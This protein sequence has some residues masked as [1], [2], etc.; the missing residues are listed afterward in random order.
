VVKFW[1]GRTLDSRVVTDSVTLSD[2]KLSKIARLVRQDELNS[3]QPNA[4]SDLTTV[5][6]VRQGNRS[7]TISYAGPGVPADVPTSVKDLLREL[8]QIHD[9]SH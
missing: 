3:V 1:R 4:S 8:Q 2:D 5:L 9:P 7:N 6:S